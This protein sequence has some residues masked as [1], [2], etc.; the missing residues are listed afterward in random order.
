MITQEHIAIA[1]KEAQKASFYETR[2]FK[3]K[4]GAIALLGGK[5]IARAHNSFH[6]NPYLFRRYGMRSSHAETTLIYSTPIIENILVIRILTD[7]TLT[8][9]K[10]CEKCMKAIT[11]SKVKSI[12][13]SDWDGD[14][15]VIK[16]K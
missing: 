11:S 15:K 4:L 12:Y 10:P 16:I 13:Y 3:Y 6:F 1:V 14:I 9:A 8:C 5:V 7:L 2:K